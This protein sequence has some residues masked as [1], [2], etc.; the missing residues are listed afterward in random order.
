MPNPLPLTVYGP[1]TPISPFVRVSGVLPGAD[2]TIMENGNPVG[3]GVAVNA[4]ELNVP[5]TVQP[6]VGHSITAIQKTNGGTSA[7]SPQV[8]LVVD[9]P[10]PLPTPV[11]LSALNTCMTD[12]FAAGLVP[13]A[14]IITSIGGTSFGSSV[15]PDTNFLTVNAAFQSRELRNPDKLYIVVKGI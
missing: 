15:A 1:V 9:V 7:P 5:L 10:D 3:H 14:N 2:V 13:G 12:I 11:I 8:I 4:G 6:P